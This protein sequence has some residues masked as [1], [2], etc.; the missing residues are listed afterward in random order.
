MYS[1]PVYISTFCAC[2]PL[3]AVVL[4][5]VC[6]ASVRHAVNHI[7]GRGLFC[8]S[9]SYVR[10]GPLAQTA[11]SQTHCTQLAILVEG[12]RGVPKKKNWRRRCRTTVDHCLIFQAIT[13]SVWTSLAFATY[14]SCSAAAT[15]PNTDKNAVSLVI[16]T[17]LSSRLL[18][19]SQFSTEMDSLLKFIF[20]HSHSFRPFCTAELSDGCSV[21]YLFESHT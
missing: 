20:P 14:S 2:F 9:S 10:L 8:W 1:C 6:V 18:K 4:H 21:A 19:S 5:T 17:F 3:S 13:L 7:M 16:S 12:D 15:S 11:F